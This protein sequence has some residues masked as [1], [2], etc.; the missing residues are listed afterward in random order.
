MSVA[1]NNFTPIPL[2][3]EDYEQLPEFARPPVTEVALSLQFEPLKGLT[4]P[5]L[6]LLWGRFKS[7][8]PG[9][10]ELPA[11]EPVLERFGAA[12]PRQVNLQFQVLDAPPPSRVWFITES[13][14][15][16]IQAQHDR[17]VHNWRKVLDTDVYPRYSNLR[18][19]FLTELET[20]RQFVEEENL[21]DLI[22]NQVEVT[23]VNTIVSGEGWERHGQLSK[24]LTI[25]SG[26][27]SDDFFK[28]PE[29]VQTSLRYV[30]PD[31]SQK[32]RGRLHINV[33]PTFTKNKSAA[34]NLTIIARCTPDGS[35]SDTLTCLD[36]AH[37]WIVKGFAS[38]TT[39]E[40][41]EVWGRKE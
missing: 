2:A 38:I 22:F 26:S 31:E 12:T 28:E 3:N 7:A 41:H 23:F 5:V 9:V 17:F 21:G 18:A 36:L 1:E 6:G 39:K 20:F 13:G 8:Y 24:V 11:L 25:H 10:Q 14:T 27:Y 32:P 37:R 4:G 16:L 34:L 15:E 19:K 33:V 35:L 40:M 30:I 29:N